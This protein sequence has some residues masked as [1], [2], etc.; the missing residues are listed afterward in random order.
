MKLDIHKTDGISSGK[1]ATLPKEVFE[2]E[3]ND[4]L[5]YLA[6]RSQQK[7]SRQGNA[8]TKTRSFVRGGGKKPWKQKGRGAARA[9]T[10][11]SPLWV[12]GGRIF[13]PHPR[14]LK[15]K[16]TKKMKKQARSS[17]FAYK[18]KQKNIM[19]LDEV[20]IENAKTKEMFQILQNLNVD[21]KKVLLLKDNYDANV[22]RAGRNIPFLTIRQASEVS[23]YDILH[24]EVLLIE[25]N[26]LEKITEVCTL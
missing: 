26:A 21:N 25:H 10:I 20:K 23:T 5:I 8:A 19:L 3:P 14:D 22:L 16:L 17:A 7:N 18:A 2:I 12:G 13:G 15:M 6:I 24:C 9:G 4:H 11:R 1:A